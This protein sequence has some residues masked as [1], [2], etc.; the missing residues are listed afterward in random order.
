MSEMPRVIF[1]RRKSIITYATGKTKSWL[2]LWAR[3]LLLVASLL[4]TLKML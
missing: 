1:T 2:K 3:I 4:P